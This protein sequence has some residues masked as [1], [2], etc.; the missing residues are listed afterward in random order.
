MVENLKNENFFGESSCDI[1]K[2]REALEGEF[3]SM[4]T[5]VAENNSMCVISILH[6]PYDPIF[7]LIGA[8]RIL[9]FSTVLSS[10]GEQI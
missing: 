3:S 8:S 2:A 4:E 9:N 6:W 5:S 7:N 1:C 10:K